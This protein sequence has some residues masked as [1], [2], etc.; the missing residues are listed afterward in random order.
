VAALAAKTDV[1][2]RAKSTV[3]S[4]TQAARTTAHQVA[5]TANRH[6]GAVFTTAAVLA[7]ALVRTLF[8]RRRPQ[9]R[10][11]MFGGRRRG[12]MTMMR[13]RRR[14]G[15]I[16][17]LITRIMGTMGRSTRGTMGRTMNRTM[18]KTMGRVRAP[19]GKTMGKTMGK[20]MGSPVRYPGRMTR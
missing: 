12:G 6:P 10:T 13:P 7:G 4:K 11:R 15:M 5:D 17:R 3:K 1:K 9:T 20:P 19:I 14:Q 18:G 16:A 8:K 2:A